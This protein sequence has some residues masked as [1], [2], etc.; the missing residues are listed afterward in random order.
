MAHDRRYKEDEYVV[1]PFYKREGDLEIKCEGI[2]SD[3]LTNRFK[4]AKQKENHKEQCCMNNYG[5]C[6]ICKVLETKYGEPC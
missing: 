2:V 6:S 4:N 5:A 3:V 1:C